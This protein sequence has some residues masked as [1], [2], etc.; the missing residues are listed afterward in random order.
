MVLALDNLGIVAQYHEEYGAAR[1]YQE[2][3]LAICRTYGYKNGLAHVLAHM[4]SRAVSEGDY[5]QAREYYRELLNVL[6]EQNYH[7]VTITCLEG[8]ATMRHKLGRPIEAARL[9]G[10][11]ERMREVNKH[12]ISA[13]YIKRYEENRDAAL[14][15][16]DPEE[17][18]W[19]WNE[20]RATS[21]EEAIA[22]ALECL[23]VS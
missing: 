16:S 11:A 5:G 1:G 19:A 12:P 15:Q 9:W 13:L 3:A 8:V 2:E 20:G 14:A 6:Q 22:Y 4:G 21:I 10:A 17:F 18:Q 7:G 23:Q